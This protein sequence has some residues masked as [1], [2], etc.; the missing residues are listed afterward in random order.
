MVE[1][2]IIAM[3]RLPRDYTL[4]GKSFRLEA[5]SSS[6]ADGFSQV[7]ESASD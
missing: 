2:K 3:G 7:W 5:I 1:L 6:G 4:D